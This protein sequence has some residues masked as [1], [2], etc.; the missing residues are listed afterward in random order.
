MIAAD[1]MTVAEAGAGKHYGIAIS[2]A[3]THNVKFDNGVFTPRGDHAVLNVTDLENALAAGNVEVSTRNGPGGELPGNINVDAS[4]TWTSGSAL[5]LDA[6]HSIYVNA[7]VVDAGS[8]ALTLTTDD[9]GAGGE[10]FFGATGNIAI[11]SLSTGLTING[12]AYTLVGDIQTLAVDVAKNPSGL[13]ALANSYDAKVDG[14]YHAAPITTALSGTFEG[15]GNTISKLTISDTTDGQAGLFARSSGIISDVGIVGANVTLNSASGEN[16][17]VLAAYAAGVVRGSYSTGSVTVSGNAA[18]GGLVGTE[19]GTVANSHSSASASGGTGSRVG[20]LVGWAN[21]STLENSYAS[22]AASGGS[23]AY[24]GGLAGFVESTTIDSCFSTGLATVGDGTRNLVAAGGLIGA[25]TGA[26]GSTL[27]VENSYAIGNATA[28]VSAEVGGLVGLAYTGTFQTSYST[29]VPSAGAKGLVGG[30][31]G[32]EKS[33][34]NAAN[35]Y[36]DTTTSGLT[37]PVGKGSGEGI[38]GLTTAQLQSGLPSGFDPTIWAESPTVN[39][40]L[41]YLI[42]NP[43]PQ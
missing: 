2:S 14:V 43:P 36:W 23:N 15:L 40:G 8:G 9:G 20:G 16:A 17:G 13:F 39:N 30:Y 27:L 28:G 22:G 19:T 3:K 4:F 41:P 26:Q 10:L 7:P 24:A 37:Q 33:G 5:V 29:G 21:S 11:W 1:F 42:A 12:Q 35:A 25:T 6:F 31:A 18:A 32:L 34:S 38:T